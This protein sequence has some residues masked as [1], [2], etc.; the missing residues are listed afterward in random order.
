MA[1]PAVETGTSTFKKAYQ[2]E[3]QL[4]TNDRVLAVKMV[5]TLFGIPI[6]SSGS[7]SLNCNTIFTKKIFS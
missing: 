4:S 1:G 6:L 7:H 5:N 3:I 2:I